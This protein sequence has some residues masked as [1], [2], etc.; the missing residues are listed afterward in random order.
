MPSVF[1]VQGSVGAIVDYCPLHAQF[2][3]HVFGDE[4][5]GENTGQSDRAAFTLS[6]EMR[7]KWK[8][9]LEKELSKISAYSPG[10]RAFTWPLISSL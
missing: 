10:L 6:P 3:A 4:P 7:G 5:A 1:P 9:D 8:A 2:V